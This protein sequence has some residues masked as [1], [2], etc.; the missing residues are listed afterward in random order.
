MR[1]GQ[2]GE[3]EIIGAVANGVGGTDEPGRR[4][5]PPLVALAV[6]V[7][8]VPIIVGIALTSG[9]GSAGHAAAGRTTAAPKA[10]SFSPQPLR[11]KVEGLSTVPPGSGAIVARMV[12]P[13][14]MRAT[15]GGRA[16]AKIGLRSDFGS[17]AVMLVSRMRR[18]WLGVISTQSGNNHL[19]WIPRKATSLSR[20]TFEIKVSLASRRL[21]VLDAGKVLA[22]YAV[23]IGRPT[24]PTPTGRFEVTDRLTT[25]DPNGPY[26]CC[27][28]ALS[29]KA[30]H[31]IQGWGGGNRIA[32]HST[33]ETW[34]IGQAVSHGC[35]RLTMAEG[36]WLMNHVP[37]GTPTVITS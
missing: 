31:A 8:A 19:G 4:F 6:L 35:L 29:A 1:S 20:V 23:A 15:P 37:L 33:P 10:L 26:G 7:P 34:S 2:R 16:I 27:V 24:A 17:P 11:A 36:R 25:G 5:S 28:V 22:R 9:G 18:D 13:T 30:P 3:R 21:T 14:V 12:Q 32:I